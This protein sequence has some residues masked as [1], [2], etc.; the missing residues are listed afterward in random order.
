MSAS[1][2][3]SRLFSIR[4]CASCRSILSQKEFNNALCEK[5]L[6]A[7][8]TATTE[9]CPNCF[10]SVIECTCQPKALSSAGSLCLRKL[11]IYHPNKDGEAQNRLIY[12][13]KH[14]R[15]KRVASFVATELY[16]ELLHEFD[17]LGISDPTAELLLVN[18]PRGRLAVAREGFDQSAE[19]CKAIS[20]ISGIPYA[21]L[22]KRK[23]GGKEQK[24]LNAAQRKKNVSKLMLADERYANLA[25]GRYII[26]F[27]DVVTTGASMSVCLPILR[28]MGIKGVICAAIAIDAKKKKEI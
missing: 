4:K 1:E 26:L 20:C 12:F 23:R 9:S 27:D 28:K 2:L 24:K 3:I 13:L 17:N 16:G 10:R 21:P 25:N 18:M 15:S 14:N 7:Y 11:F 5:C 22:I 8:R 6:Q 19:V